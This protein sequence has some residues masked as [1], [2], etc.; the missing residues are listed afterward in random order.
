[1]NRDEKRKIAEAIE[2]FVRGFAFTK[3]LTHPYEV[4]FFNGVWAMHDAQRP[5]NKGY[6]KEEYGLPRVANELRQGSQNETDA[7]AVLSLGIALEA[8]L[9]FSGQ[10]DR[11]LGQ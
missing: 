11:W 1:M 6:R 9:G 10:F 5:S 7:R 4:V 3:S 8:L 2:V